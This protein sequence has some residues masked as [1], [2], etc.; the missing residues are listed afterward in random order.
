MFFL[1]LLGLFHSIWEKKK[2]MY[3]VVKIWFFYDMVIFILSHDSKMAGYWH[4]FDLIVKGF[5]SITYIALKIY[6]ISFFS[7][8]YSKKC[9]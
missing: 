4:N 7:W 9:C 3:F 8:N 6:F 5:S 2:N 1:V